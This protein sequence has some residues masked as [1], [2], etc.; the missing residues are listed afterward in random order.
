MSLILFVRKFV[1]FR[2]YNTIAL[3]PGKWDAH[4]NCFSLR[5]PNSLGFQQRLGSSSKTKINTSQYNEYFHG[6]VALHKDIVDFSYRWSLD[7][8]RRAFVEVNRVHKMHR[9]TLQAHIGIYSFFLKKISEFVLFIAR[10]YIVV[11]MGSF[12]VKFERKCRWLASD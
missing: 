1:Y 11:Y 2:Y 6:I 5:A 7:A 3:V 8:T 12:E 4:E 9:H 10:L